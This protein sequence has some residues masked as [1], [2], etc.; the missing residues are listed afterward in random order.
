MIYKEEESTQT[1]DDV[2]VLSQEESEETSFFSTNDTLMIEMDM[3]LTKQQWERM[4]ESGK[5]KKR[6]ALRDVAKYW[7]NGVVPYELQP[8]TFTSSDA[9]QIRAA[10][11]DYHSLTCI[12][13]RRA[14]GNDRRKIRITSGQGCWSNIGMLSRGQQISLARGCR[15]KS[16]ILH[17]FGHAL[18]MFHEQSRP[19]RDSYITI[20][21]GNVLKSMAYNFNKHGN[22]R[23]N[24]YNVPYDYH[25]VMH[26]GQTAFSMNGKPTIITK[27]KSK[28][29][30]IGTAKG[31]SFR[32]IKVLNLMYK[33]GAK[34]NLKAKDCPGEGFVGKNCKCLCPGSPIKICGDTSVKPD[35][36]CNDMHGS[37]SYWAAKGQCNKYPGFMLKN[38]RRS[39][40][41]CDSDASPIPIPKCVDMN[42]YCPH[43]AR[44]KYC[45]HYRYKK[46]MKANCKKSCR[47]CVRGKFD[48]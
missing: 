30:L 36:K 31:L 13:F 20:R 17:E 45:F 5:V 8:G 39:C 14:N 41:A 18:G 46:Y 32:D 24:T 33:C 38:C 19:D 6:K 35:K 12:K 28:Q 3:R 27:D 1:N 2:I 29:Y 48:K 40:K 43:W 16:T 34:C 9:A 21:F 4:E 11:A 37:C 47:M 7:T 10:I 26:Y 15:R 23:I 25:S 44:K 22:D 42:K